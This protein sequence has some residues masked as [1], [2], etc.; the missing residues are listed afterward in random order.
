MTNRN[1]QN[2]TVITEGC[3]YSVPDFTS[4]SNLASDNCSN[5]GGS[6]NISQ[7]PA[8]NTVIDLSQNDVSFLVT[9]TYT[10]ASNNQSSCSF[11]V[12]AVCLREVEIPQFYTPNGDGTNDFFEIR[13]LVIYPNNTLK[14]FNRWGDLV[15][16]KE[17]YDNSWG[18]ES[19]SN[20]NELPSGT[21]FYVFDIKDK[22]SKTGFVHLKK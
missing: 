14:I 11:N 2:D 12:N 21:Y 20:S 4:I 3:S 10:D 6:A 5:G 15:Y 19:N 13:N 17:N 7:V 22:E 1:N 9:L 16:E 8:P 18:G